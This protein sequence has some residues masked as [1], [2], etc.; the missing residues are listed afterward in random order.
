MTP[1]ESLLESLPVEIQCA[2]FRRLDPIELISV[3]QASSQLRTLIKPTRKLLVERLLALEC[4]RKYGGRSYR[5]YHSH[6][7]FAPG[8]SNPVWESMRFACSGCLRLLPRSQFLDPYLT[9]IAYRKPMRGSPA[10]TPRTSWKPSL[11]GTPRDPKVKE[12]HRR[13]RIRYATAVHGN[14]GPEGPPDNPT[15]QL[16]ALLARGIQS[17]QGLSLE[18]PDDWEGVDRQEL[19]GGEILAVELVICGS[20]RHLRRC[21]ECLYQQARIS[22]TPSTN[23][24]LG[25][26]YVNYGTPHV[27]ILQT[28]MISFPTILHRLFPGLEMSSKKMR[29]SV[30][31]FSEWGDYR[32]YKET[33][34]WPMCTIRCPGCGVWQELR[35]FRCGA[36]DEDWKV[37]VRG[38]FTRGWNEDEDNRSYIDSLRCNHCLAERDGRDQLR[39]ELS[40]WFWYNLETEMVNLQEQLLHHGLED[41]EDGEER[42]LIEKKLRDLSMPSKRVSA[43]IW[44]KAGMKMVTRRILVLQEGHNRNRSR[45]SKPY[46]DI[47]GVEWYWRVQGA[48]CWLKECTEEMEEKGDDFL[49]SWALGRHATALK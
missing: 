45:Y 41:D 29:C 11:R 24:D 17:F 38:M 28:R 48:W 5:Y 9:R 26:R 25:F 36:L 1:S 4:Q 22:D 12:E 35:A 10:A 34:V 16:Q 20:K 46:G 37:R 8:W 31:V 30:D 13:T 23:Y 2:I 39:R 15:E 47:G 49:V 18:D 19:L 14:W 27:P 3:S 32:L 7:I 33:G 42:D 6:N 21:K 43:P 40:A 44:E